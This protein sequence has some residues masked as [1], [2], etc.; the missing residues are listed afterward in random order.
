MRQHNDV[1]HLTELLRHIRFMGNYVEPGTGELPVGQQV[2]KSFLVDYTASGNVDEITLGAKGPPAGTR[3]TSS[4][5]RREA[6][7]RREFPPTDHRNH[8]ADQHRDRTTNGPG[9]GVAHLATTK[10]SESLERPDQTEHCDDQPDR[11]CNNESLSHIGILFAG[12]GRSG[13]CGAEGDA[14]VHEVDDLVAASFLADL[15]AASCGSAGD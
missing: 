14:E 7:F 15:C 5:R 11:E 9:R 3:W 12:F 10:N 1:V 13:R 2:R 6:L 8:D 4:W